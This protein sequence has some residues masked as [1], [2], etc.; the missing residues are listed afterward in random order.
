MLQF[1]LRRLLTF[2]LILLIANFIGFAFAFYFEPVVSSSNPYISGEILL[3]PIFPEYFAYLSKFANLDFGL[4]YNGEPV[5]V[6]IARLSLNSF[7][8]VALAL[9]LSIALGIFLGRLAVRRDSMK[10]SAWLTVLSTLGLAS[11]GF[12]IAILLIT[13]FLLITIYGPGVVIPFQGF[14][15]DAHLILPVLVLMV[16]PTVKIAQVTGS[17][18]VD[19]LQKPYVKGWHQPWA[20]LPAMKNRFAFRSV[21]APILQAVAYSARLMVAELIIIER[22]FNWPGLGKFIGICAA[23]RN[24]IWLHDCVDALHHGGV[25]DRAGVDL[26]CSLIFHH[27]D[28][29]HGGPASANGCPRRRQWGGA[30][31]L[32]QKLRHQNWTLI[33]GAVLV[34]F[35][36]LIAFIGPSL[37]PQDPMK[38]N[39]T[40]SMNGAISHSAISRISDSRISPWHRPLGTRPV[41]SH[42]VGRQT[43]DDHGHCGCGLS[44]CRWHHP[45]FTDRLGRWTQS[46]PT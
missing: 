46:P 31:N 3:P 36:I 2:P 37:A 44:A 5:L 6:A 20:Y 42:F 39:F 19:E 4:T 11:P 35:M 30:M 12:Y 26:S 8:L 22:L 15:W 27:S 33:L 25:V 40:L 34:G 41:E 13:L 1:I 38:E 16:Q 45:W 29:A 21:V 28:R 18:L 24:W 17:T 7:G 23:T 14:G 43:D 10:V 32:M 9:T